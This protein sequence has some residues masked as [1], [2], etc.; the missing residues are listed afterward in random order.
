[1]IGSAGINADMGAIFGDCLR[2]TREMAWM[3]T[4]AK[5][6]CHAGIGPAETGCDQGGLRH[7]AG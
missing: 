7:H 6:I 5:C 2:G 1:M 4:V 3:A